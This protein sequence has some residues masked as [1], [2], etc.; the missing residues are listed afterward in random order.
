MQGG[1]K[2]DPVTQC[3]GFPASFCSLSLMSTMINGVYALPF[4]LYLSVLLETLN[5]F[6]WTV[7]RAR[8]LKNASGKCLWRECFGS[9]WHI[10][11]ML[12]KLSW[13]IFLLNWLLFGMLMES[14]CC[15]LDLGS[16]ESQVIFTGMEVT[17]W[18]SRVLPELCSQK[19]K[20]KTL[21]KQL[22]ACM[23]KQQQQKAHT[24]N[25]LVSVL[26][27]KCSYDPPAT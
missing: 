14:S 24:Q 1:S 20:K 7:T 2:L 6:F 23:Q 8:A 21:S 9:Q 25:L 5:F 22:H 3:M 11:W 17:M 15:S 19:L 4:Q 12:W 26:Q 10:R 27:K 18:E 16:S 13:F